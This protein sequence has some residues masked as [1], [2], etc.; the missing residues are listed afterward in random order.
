[1]MVDG[2]SC[3]DGIRS[4]EVCCRN[5]IAAASMFPRNASFLAVV[6]VFFARNMRLHVSVVCYRYHTGFEDRPIRLRWQ[7]D[8]PD[9]GPWNVSM[10]LALG[11][12]V[13]TS[14]L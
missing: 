13:L 7:V 11:S 12:H 9:A 3:L 6:V 10:I 1:M 5:A 14:F 4:G 8:G 2:I